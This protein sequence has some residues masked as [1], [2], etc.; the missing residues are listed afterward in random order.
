[1][2]AELIASVI[3]QGER[4]ATH[5]WEYGTF[6]EALLE[7][8]DPSSAVFGAD[9]FPGG[10][11]PVLQV[12]Q[13]RS[14]AYAEPHISTNSTTLV[15]GDGAAGDPASLGV[16]AI[17]IGQTDDTF[18][19]AAERQVQHLLDDVP[20]WAN[21]AISHRESV[22]ELW[23]D[24][25]YM[26]PPTL[27]YWAVQTG[28][29]DLLATAVQQCLLYR[30]VLGVEPQDEDDSAAAAA[31]LWHHIIGPESQDLGIW[32]TGN[33]WAAAGMA[34]VL[35]TAR[36]A[37]EPG[38]SGSSAETDGELL[39]MLEG[40]I[41]AILD[42]AIA[43]DDA[44]PAEPLLRNYL[45][46]T[47]W[48]GELSGTTLLAATAYRMAVL[49]PAAFGAEA[50]EGEGEGAGYVAWADAKRREITGRIGSDGLLYPVVN[51]LDW[52]DRTPAAESPEA[53]SFAVLLFAAYRD[54]CQGSSDGCEI[55]F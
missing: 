4:L 20:R 16:S 21:G 51:P 15:D 9:P 22:A 7:W 39:P 50:G 17:L 31:G 32:S 6:A 29:A 25:V 40:A 5:S 8:Y 24:F 52:S 45:N 38:L 3:A 30:D 23:A 14:L 53:Q 27:A 18:L 43:L 34:R 26:A 46:D 54:Y 12:N 13:T 44:E 33:A 37:P 28:D 47:T 36:R 35:A 1:M 49:A 41:R 19:A 55:E 11:I 2:S 10:K 42:G 48:F